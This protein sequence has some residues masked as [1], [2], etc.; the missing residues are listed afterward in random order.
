MR[1][2]YV[3]S[4]EKHLLIKAALE[5]KQGDGAFDFTTNQKV[6]RIT[7]LPSSNVDATPIVIYRSVITLETDFSQEDEG[8]RQEAKAQ[9][10]F[11]SNDSVAILNY[12]ASPDVVVP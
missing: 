2:Y 10:E 4:S 11:F 12:L 1:T 9:A 7:D 8:I 5:N 3:F 6:V